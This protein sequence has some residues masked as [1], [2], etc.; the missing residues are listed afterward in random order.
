MFVLVSV[1]LSVACDA[2]F[3]YIYDSPPSPSPFPLSPL[4]IIIIVSLAD[5]IRGEQFFPAIHIYTLSL[6]ISAMHT[7]T[8]FLLEKYPRR[9]VII[10]ENGHIM[11]YLPYIQNTNIFRSGF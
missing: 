9:D 7:R 8:H 6:S 1:F 10:S 5:E 4:L 2:E 3:I 11:I